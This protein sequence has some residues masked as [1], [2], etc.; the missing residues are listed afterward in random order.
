MVVILSSMFLITMRQILIFNKNFKVV[1]ATKDSSHPYNGT[2]SSNGYK[3]NGVFSPYLHL[4]PRNTYKFDQSDSTNSGH[5]LRFYLDAS[6]STAFTTGVTTSGTSGSSGAYTQI[7]VSDTT[8]SV[9]HYQ[10]S[11]HANMG[12]VQQQLYK[13]SNKF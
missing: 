1:V 4:I 10:C 7:V 12:W 11:A 6:K 2:G 3:I 8:P 5:P 13:K 9:L